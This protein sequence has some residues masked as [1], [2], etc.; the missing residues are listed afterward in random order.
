MGVNRERKVDGRRTAGQDPQITLGREDVDLVGEQIDLDALQE[1]GRVLEVALEIG[2]LAQPAELL[3]VLRVHAA[4]D[5]LLVLP[6]RGDAVLGYAVH[7]VRPDL[8]LDAL[9]SG[10]NHR[11]MQRLVHVGLGQRDVVLEA[12]GNRRPTR[13]H[14]AQ[15]RVAISDAL[16]VQPKSDDV[17][18]LI[19]LTL[20]LLHLAID[21]VQV[22]GAPVD[23]RGKALLC[24]AR[25]DG[26]THALD[27]VLALFVALGQLAR[28]LLVRVGLQVPERQV[29]EL[30]LDVLHA[31]A[32]RQ[33]RVDLP[34][35]AR[36]ALDRIGLHVSERPHV[37][38]AVAQLD[39]QDPQ[40][41]GH[42]HDHLAEALG[43]PILP[44]REVDLTE[45]GDA[46]D[47]GRHLR[48][49]AALDLLQ[50]GLGVLDDV[51]EQTSANAR[52]VQPQLGDDARHARRVNEV[53]IAAL[54]R[55]LAVRPLGKFVGALDELDVRCRVVALDLGNEFA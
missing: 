20:L 42:R 46:I 26:A 4:R 36:D 22:L 29:F 10:A 2:Q 6:V 21:G 12:P 15:G 48:P 44:R 30:A 34:G 50:A 11:R 55:L 1:L 52:G 35:L 49:E 45:L 33:R 43:L 18:D 31:E 17:V 25:R 41:L 16:D 27:V 32:T 24:Q 53:R 19:E 54:A 9:P 47:D 8:N 38:E 5:A 3:G 40:V 51:V 28:K 39:Q 13:M 14:G 23:D 37:V 7:L